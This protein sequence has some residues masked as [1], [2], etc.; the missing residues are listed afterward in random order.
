VIGRP[1]IE[2]TVPAAIG[3]VPLLRRAAAS[4]CPPNLATRVD[5][6]RLGV[7]EA[8]N[9]LLQL[10]APATRFVLGVTSEDAGLSL[11]IRSDAAIGDVPPPGLE[12]SWSWTLLKAVADRATFRA[13]GAG[14]VV[15]LEFLG[16]ART[17]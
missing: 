14:P 8:C 2:V 1:A 16:E 15:E 11:Q 5:D 4:G 10:H 3:F 6:V 12:E 13:S 7:T 9:L 17:A